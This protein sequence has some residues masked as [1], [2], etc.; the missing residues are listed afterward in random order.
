VTAESIMVVLG[1]LVAGSAIGVVARPLVG[2][3]PVTTAFTVAGAAGAVVSLASFLLLSQLMLVESSSTWT[4]VL[5]VLFAGA[6]A[7]IDS[8]TLARMSARAVDRLAAAANRMGGGDL[9][10]RV[11]ALEACRELRAL[12]VALDSMAGRL[13][14]ATARERELE[15]RRRDLLAAMSHDLRTPLAGVIAMAEAIEDGV[16]SDTGTLRRYAI[17]MRRAAHALASLVDDLFELTQLDALDV[18]GDQRAAALHE[19]A[20]SA[21]TAVRGAAIARD[22]RIHRRLGEVAAMPCSP[23]LARVI[24]NLLDN[25]VRHSPSGGSVILAARLEHAHLVITVEDAGEG[26]DNRM[27]DQLFEPFWRADPARLGGGAGLGLPLAKRITEALGGGISASGEQGQGAVFAIT[28]PTRT[29]RVPLERT[30]VDE[31]AEIGRVPST[32]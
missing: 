21:C 13:Q 2:R 16:V 19:V 28:L 8:W 9:E 17:E 32:R 3:L 31:V 10:A 5:L 12:G 22:V 20:E 15:E 27:A 1:V 26:F 18:A 11:G 14:A 30:Q 23:R 24:Q 4:L 25:A 6:V 29:E 7:V